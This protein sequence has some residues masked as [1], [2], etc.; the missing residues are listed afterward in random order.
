M[1]KGNFSRQSGIVYC[2]SKKECEDVART[3]AQSGISAKPYH[4]GLNPELRSKT[5]VSFKADRFRNLND[6]CLVDKYKSIKPDIFQI[7]HF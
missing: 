4:A 1:I 6:Y 2:L 5:Q 7:K 3:L